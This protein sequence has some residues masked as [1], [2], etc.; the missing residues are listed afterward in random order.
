MITSCLRTGSRGLSLGSR[1]AA[2]SPQP[3]QR[4]RTAHP[5]MP[6]ALGPPPR[7]SGIS[8]HPRVRCSLAS[9]RSTAHHLRTVWPSDSNMLRLLLILVEP[10]RVI[11]FSTAAQLSERW[12]AQRHTSASQLVPLPKGVLNT[13]RLLIALWSS[14][15]L[16]VVVPGGELRPFPKMLEGLTTSRASR[17]P[18]ASPSERPRAA[19]MVLPWLRRTWVAPGDASTFQKVAE[20]EFVTCFTRHACVAAG[21][22]RD[23]VD[24][25]SIITTDDGGSTWMQS[26]LPGDAYERGAEIGGLTCTTRTVASS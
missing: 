13:T 16:T 2:S 15:L 1:W 12:H 10:G 8:Q 17:R 22:T 14:R 26:S 23:E 21:G 18:I 19:P 7:P 3:A 5:S 4:W 9:A 11:G 25:N 20:P 24:A 6:L